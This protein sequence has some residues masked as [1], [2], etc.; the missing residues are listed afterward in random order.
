[1]ESKLKE[2]RIASLYTIFASAV[3]LII[4]V[5]TI[6]MSLSA[7]RSYKERQLTH[8]YRESTK[9]KFSMEEK[10]N[11]MEDMSEFFG[12]K[13]QAHNE[14]SYDYI[15]EIIRNDRLRVDYVTPEGYMVIDSWDGIRKYTKLITDRD[16]AWIT[17]ARDEPNVLKFALPD[18]G[19]VSQK[20]LWSSAFGMQNKAGEFLGYISV[21]LLIDDFR[22]FLVRSVGADIDFLV[23]D[24][25]GNIIIDSSARYR[26]G[27]SIT[28]ADAVA[29]QVGSLMPKRFNSYFEFDE[30]VYTHH[31]KLSRFPFYLLV[32]ERDMFSYEHLKEDLLPQIV[33]NLLLAIVFASAILFLGYR[34]INPMIILAQEGEKI[35]KGHPANIPHFNIREIN[36]LAGQMRNINTMHT[37]LR[38][39]QRELTSANEQLKHI[40]NFIKSN[41]SF[42]S[43]EL[44]NPV[45]SILGFASMLSERMGNNFD[46][47]SKSYVDMIK[48]A[49]SH[50]DKQ[51]DFFLRVFKFRD[52]GKVIETKPFEVGEI[53]ESNVNMLRHHAL[54]KKIKINTK[55]DP[56]VKKMIGDPIMIGQ[57]L[58][59]LISNSIKYNVE[60]GQ[61]GIHAYL[62][63]RGKAKKELVFEVNDTGIGMSPEEVVRIFDKFERIRNESNNGIIGYGIGLAYV[64]HA[65]VLHDGEISVKSK[66]DIG[67]QFTVIFPPER[68]LTE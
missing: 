2:V 36:L 29:K 67:T 9:L 13:I 15:A 68:V 50:Q 24:I 61:V 56:H 48:E 34:I 60:K 45:S 10:L 35:S 46:E 63:R 14:I 42:L 65:V 62:R 66:K 11:F 12:K 19:F 21:N 6:W 23:I 64:K 32:G 40:N 49:A 53:I 43:H 57:M 7:F 22:A 30:K 8:V 27:D 1:L 33:V 25:D 3:A 5:I 38:H 20:Y 55:I 44:R 51:I 41:M 52:K 4:V 17:S 28:K 37:K 58:Q 59:N 54:S 18:Y 26:A 39:K 47:E 16:R 31:V